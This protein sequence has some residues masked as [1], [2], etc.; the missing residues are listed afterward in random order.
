MYQDFDTDCRVIGTALKPYC[1]LWGG[2]GGGG[3][4]TNQLP[5]LSLM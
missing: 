4:A 3:V 2:G 1:H 5:S